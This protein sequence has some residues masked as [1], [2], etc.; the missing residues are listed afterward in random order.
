MNNNN[1]KSL[2]TKKSANI[3]L[4]LK[5]PH[6][7]GRLSGHVHP[8]SLWHV[9]SL[10]WSSLCKVGGGG[11]ARSRRTRIHTQASAPT[12]PG[13]TSLQGGW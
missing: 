9:T 8:I 6:S 12:V 2:T 3:P 1:K 13:I 5:A 11:G 10:D 4:W 7:F